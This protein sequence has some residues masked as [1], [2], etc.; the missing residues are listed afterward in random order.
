VHKIQTK[1]EK[2]REYEQ[3]NWNI[4]KLACK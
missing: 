2:E 3:K 1:R 4:Q